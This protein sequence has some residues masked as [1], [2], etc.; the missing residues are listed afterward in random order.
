MHRIDSEKLILWLEDKLKK[1]KSIPTR[2]AYTSVLLALRNDEFEKESST[3]L[4]EL[5]I[6][7]GAGDLDAAL[8]FMKELSQDKL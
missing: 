6:K 5:C 3:R 8:D 1:T 7:A 4:T 2:R